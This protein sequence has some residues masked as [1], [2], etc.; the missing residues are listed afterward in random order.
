MGPK[1]ASR[2][3]RDGSKG[4]KKSDAFFVF[5]FELLWDLWGAVLGAVLLSQIGL[6][7]RHRFTIF[8][9]VF[10]LAM[11]WSQDGCQDRP[12]RAQEP[13]RASQEPSNLSIWVFGG[14]F[15]TSIC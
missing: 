12:K 11:H 7:G 5:I 3:I 2:P 14:S 1:I 15:W 9:L 6:K 10:D 4:D 13:P 8:D